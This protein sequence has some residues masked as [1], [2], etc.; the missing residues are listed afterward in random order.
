MKLV[1]RVLFI[2]VVQFIP[3]FVFCECFATESVQLE[4]VDS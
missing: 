1:D 4:A 3:V 2:E